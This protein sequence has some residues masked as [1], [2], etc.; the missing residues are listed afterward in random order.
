MDYIKGR[1]KQMITD[2]QKT[3]I[4]LIITI[5][6]AT[7]LNVYSHVIDGDSVKFSEEDV[8][9]IDELHR[10]LIKYNDSQRNKIPDFIK[11]EILE[12]EGDFKKI[13]DKSSEWI[14]INVSSNVNEE[15]ARSIKLLMSWSGLHQDDISSL[16]GLSFCKQVANRPFNI[17]EFVSDHI[18]YWREHGKPDVKLSP[19][20]NGRIMW[21]WNLNTNKRK[22]GN[23]HVGIDE[24]KRHFVCFESDLG[25]YFP[26]GE[27]MERIYSEI[28]QEPD[29][30]GIHLG[31]GRR[32]HNPKPIK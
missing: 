17:F 23:I 15:I 1:T 11:K 21:L 20:G 6:T 3:Y 29:V 13:P 16:F 28:I 18:L 19:N 12:N 24:K 2:T 10:N 22:F 9:Q 7:V 25:L 14:S 26:E 4:L 32:E 31:K 8:I 27:M 5:F 30:A